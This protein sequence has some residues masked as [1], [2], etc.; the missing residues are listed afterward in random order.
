M[1]N[2]RSRR[3]KSRTTNVSIF[4]Y[5]LATLLSRA[6]AALFIAIQSCYTKLLNKVAIQS[7][8]TELLYKVAIQSCYTELLYS[9]RPLPEL[10]C[11]GR[12][13]DGRPSTQPAQPSQP[14]S[15]ASGASQS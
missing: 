13:G 15:P 10:Y 9:Q 2:F 3:E 1:P 5:S 14:V 4:F 6:R 7:C 12:G 11:G 8:Y